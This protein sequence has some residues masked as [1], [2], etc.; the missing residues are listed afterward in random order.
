MHQRRW[1]ELIK[2]YNLQVHYHPGKANVVADALNHKSHCHSLVESD[3]HLSRLL[4]LAVLHN[5]TVSCT[6]KSRIIELQKTDTGIFHIKRKMK[7]QETKHFRV[8]KE[9]VLWFKDR[10]V[11]PKDRELRNHIMFEA[12]S[13]KL[14]INPG[15]NK[16]YY[17]LKPYYWW[18]KM[19]KEIAAYVVRC[20]T[21]CRVKAVHMKAG[22]LQPLSIPGW[23]WDEISMDFIVGLPP[24]VKNHNSIWVIVDRL[25]KSAHFIPVRADY[26][27]TDYA[28]LYFN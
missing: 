17:D 10:L 3:F 24:T 8:D 21:C 15:S 22:L 18:T 13:S 26:C 28:E 11:V 25:T 5:I 7:E 23:K 2:D 4:H 1:L 19:R 27:P 20:D 14:S 9:G 16:M 12:H 6:L